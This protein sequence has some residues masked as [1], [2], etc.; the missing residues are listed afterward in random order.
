MRIFAIATTTCL[1]IVGNTCAEE[2][3]PGTKP[4]GWDDD[5]TSRLVED[6]DRFLLSELQQSITN[7]AKHW[8]RD[9]S[10]PEAYE[11]SVEPNRKRL[12]H[13]LGLRDQRVTFDAPQLL[14]TTKQS[15]LI[16]KTDGFEV[17]AIQWPV[18][19]DPDG[20]RGNIVV[21]GEG[22]LVVPTG[23][24]IVADIVAIADADQTPEQ[25]VGMSGDIPAMS[26][27]AR[28]LADSG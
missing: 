15:A 12:R 2:T 11:K 23:R 7:R 24:E 18:L 4:L 8:Q 10:S 5:I 3:L 9:L 25:I 22:L 17:F 28:R 13:I 21:H 27:F 19:A 20:N 16:G 26:Q 6:A 1:F 14:A